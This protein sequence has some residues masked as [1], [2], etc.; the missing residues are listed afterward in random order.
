[1][2]E[3][4]ETTV[5]D[6]KVQRLRS[7]R[8]PILWLMAA[9]TFTVV[10][11]TGYWLLTRETGSDAADP[12]A[13]PVETTEV[14]RETITDTETWDGT[15]GY[16]EPFTASA[17][18]QGTVTR[19][20]EED[21]DVER[22]TELYRLD[23]EPVIAMTGTIPMYRELGSGSSG[24]DVEQL[25]ENLSELGYDGFTVDEYYTWYTEAA[26]QEWQDDVGADATGAVG[27]EDI[28]FIPEN[29][30]V[31][32]AHTGVGDQIQSGSPVI[33]INDPDPV[34]NMEVEAADRDLLEV[35]TEVTVQLPGNEELTATVSSASAIPAEQSEDDDSESESIIE[36]E[37][38]LSD[39]VDESLLGAS[40]DVLV[41]VDERE[42][43][44]TVPVNALL[45]LGDGDYGLEV[46]AEDGTTSIV[47][48]ETGLFED[49]RV[50]VEGEGLDG[51]T[52]VG[53]AAR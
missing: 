4:T 9:L 36:V 13:G 40:V 24:I 29:G 41:G 35:D 38:T 53:V 19:L 21:S 22:G 30:S 1:M 14:T 47:P 11:G 50:E 18:A 33:D 28:V 39:E 48:V 5:S 43:V 49:N 46:V 51:G 2:T 42:D 6:H 32:A 12:S 52:V 17:A 8:R 34:V 45:A 7:Y 27:P 3:A 10:A 31:A 25:E 44:L 37:A 15:I 23:E 16:A 26:V 20:A